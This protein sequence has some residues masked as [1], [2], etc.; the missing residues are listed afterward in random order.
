MPQRSISR[1]YTAQSSTDAPATTT[2]PKPACQRRQFATDSTTPPNLMHKTIAL[3]D[4][5]EWCNRMT[6]PFN[7]PDFPG[8]NNGLQFEN[9]G[10]ISKIGAAVD[11]NLPTFGLA[12]QHG[13]DFL[14][15]HHGLFWERPQ[16]YTGILRR[17]I[18]ELIDHNIAVYSSHLPLDSHPDFGNNA[19]IADALQLNRC[20]GF[21]P[22]EGRDIG[23]IAAGIGRHDLEERLRTL[24]P[25]GFRSITCGSAH[26]LRIAI[27]SGAGNDAVRAAI[28]AGADTLITGELKQQYFTDAT[29]RRLN[30]YLCGHYATE[31]FGV[32]ALAERLAHSFGLPWEFLDTGCPL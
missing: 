23:V 29:E 31:T 24:F 32:C 22:Y 20:G 10:R 17:K 30:L 11:A 1:L 3:A 19:R 28:E 6:N 21:L 5:V 25:R 7:H 14:I 15:V 27:C 18:G 16:A 12:G 9:G 4:A 26:P 2:H 13:C 8:A